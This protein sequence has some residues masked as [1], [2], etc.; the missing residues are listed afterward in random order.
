[1]KTILV[2]IDF[3]PV[4]RRVIDEAIDLARVAKARLVLL[5]AVQ[6]P[7]IVATDLAPLVGEALQLTAEVERGARRHLLRLQKSLVKRGVPVETLC[8]Q[9]FPTALI[10]AAAKKT[11]AKYIVIG[12]HGHTA[13]YDLVVGST[14]SGVL[15]RAPCPVVV[16]PA[17]RKGKARRLRR[18]K[19]NRPAILR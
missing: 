16:V 13:F 15:K 8:A 5:H 2:P 12:S 4:S 1:M 14:A 10:A 6:L 19:V 3:S 7:A 17:E 18:D 11:G 9:G